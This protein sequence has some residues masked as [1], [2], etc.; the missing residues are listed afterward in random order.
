MN[1]EKIAFL[2][3]FPFCGDYQDL[4]GGL[5]Q[6][7]VVFA[8]VNKEKLHMSVDAEFRRPTIPAE[9]HTLEGRIAAEYGLASVAIN[10]KTVRSTPVKAPKK[11][12]S[13]SGVTAPR[14]KEPL[15]PGR[16]IYGKGIRGE[17]VPMG[18]LSAESGAVSVRGE[19]FSVE[20]RDIVKTGAWVLGI[21]ITD[22]TGSVKVSG[23]FKKPE[24]KQTL[25][26]IKK[27]MYI[28]VFGN[29]GYDRYEGD[30]TMEPKSIQLSEKPARRD[31]APENEKRC[32]LHLHTRYSTMDALTDPTEAVARAAA[33][34]HK[35][36]A[37]T[38][39]GVAQAFP[40]V[41]HAGD[42]F[43]IKIIYGVEG[44]YINDVDDKLVF[45]GEPHGALSEEFCAFDTETTGLD[46]NND[47]MTEIGAVIM[48][49][50]E[51][52]SRFQTF[53]NP[54]RHIPAE[55]TELTGITD[56][57]VF[58]AP[59]EGE[60]MRKFLAFAKD[61]PLVAHN[62]EFDIGFLSATARRCGIDFHPVFMDTLT[63]SQSLLP[64]MK[65]FKLDL[66][67]DRLGLPTF[68][69]HRADDDA[70]ACGRIMAK[71]IEMLAER[72]IT[73][74]AELESY[75]RAER[76]AHPRAQRLKHIILLVKDKTGLKNLYELISKSHLEHFKKNPVIPK[77]LLLQY[78]E[79]IIVGSACE[80]GEV[81]DAVSRKKS[82]E[83]L[84]RLCA[85]YDYLEIQPI[86]NNAFMLEN[87]TAKNEEE[88]R[89]FNR[90]VVELGE[91]LGKPV[92]AT[93]DV[94]FL[95]PEQEIYRRIL[96]SGRGFQD[97]DRSMPLYFKTT[98]EMLR[99]F[100]YLGG[101]KCR[102]VVVT[103]P[104]AIADACETI[105]LLP[106]DLYAPKI[107]NSAEDL[108]SLVYGKMHELYGEHPPQV[109]QD[110]VDVEMDAILGRHYDVIYMS[111]QKLVAKSLE[112]GYLV[113]SRGSVGSSL[114]AYMAG[115]TEV[116][117]LPPHYL[118]PN[119]KHTEFFKETEYGCGA[120]MPDKDCPE[121]GAKLKKE[122]FNIPF[123]TFLGF[124]GDKVPDIDLNFSGEYQS[125]AHEYTR[126]LFGRD[127]VFKA[128]TI[129][130]LAEKTAYGH[131]KHYLEDHGLKVTKAEENRLTLGCVG[132]KRTTGQH[133]GG[134]V[135]IPQDM[136]VT[137]FC[138]VQH[139]ADDPD[140][141]IITTHFEY[142][143][144][145]ANLLK[146]DELGHDDP[147]MIRMLEDL[148]GVD[149]RAIPLDDKDTMSIFKSP[150]VLGLPEDDPVIGKTGTI[151]IPEFG[152]GFTR[153]ML[154]DTQPNKFAT[155]VRL[156]GFSHGT[157]VWN[158]NIHDLVVNKVADVNE[159]V[160]C[161]DDIMLYLMDKGMEP[162][163]AFKFMEAV[164]KNF[165]RKGKPWP[166][167]IVEEMEGLGVPEWY[168]ESCRKIQYLFPKAH[169]VAYV[170]M[171]FRI[172]YFKVHYP[173]AYY[174]CYFYRRSQKD[175]FDAALMTR[176]I[177]PVR[178]K[179]KDIREDPKPSA[180]DSDTLTTLEAV[181]EF[182]MRGFTFAK[183]DIYKSHA[184]KFII[185]DNALVPPFVAI[186]G[187]GE[188]A[189]N[190]LMNCREGGKHFI[191]IE[192]LAA[193]CPKVS[194]AH[195]QQ[196]K[197]LGALG[198]LPETSQMSLF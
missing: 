156:S 85:L 177:E 104:N 130:T 67:T 162:K 131:V 8:T 168:I 24:D 47:R 55:I 68:N 87:G 120:D 26:Q 145:E 197:E 7:T 59:D 28:T 22:Y 140:S 127:H 138:P 141:D 96:L 114:V 95:N 179:M 161:R 38:D 20:N 157:D 137:D 3:M 62:A 91:K 187:L 31:T 37:V 61:R 109:V 30:I 105:V 178:R 53:V 23:Y 115:I 173:L 46:P 101:D 139:P 80:A 10:D 133:P 81:F 165:L 172:A 99:E 193:A 176:G 129:G 148:T 60:A 51:V 93:G 192:E 18:E 58:D 106:K 100:A 16:L 2:T 6:A 181:Y 121:C 185:D 71:L 112:A 49:G 113:G 155:L 110:R 183:M 163:R 83:E 66:V 195:I 102:E 29:V 1:E 64:D 170:T 152:T 180:K 89:D 27:G 92:V 40:E 94:H 12:A 128:G 97:A 149:A 56:R 25:S 117:A 19:V 52:V 34:G 11:A 194:S 77:S 143:S 144:M 126:K 65:R 198:D 190:D 35:A 103:A 43:G 154:V 182:Y 171:A 50:S 70:L 142:H 119:C 125:R 84:A 146:L 48:K 186:A 118:C 136:D 124:G 111:A 73:R 147:T 9:R 42:K 74:Q 196:L 188:A 135:I 82:D 189:A 39:H 153:Q 17:T 41:W 158:G 33:W 13:G 63:L 15:T 108:K 169:A 54:D 122:G 132:V 78:R 184:I 160:G 72:G 90:R 167:G 116:N 159:C 174:S 21:E 69:H 164:R 107:E 44:Y 175:S 45:Y 191:S 4:C 32:E 57:D 14:P 151:G 123:E 88:L 75:T 5:E 36:I 150:R 98:D 79:G 166:E 76:N 86:C 134:L